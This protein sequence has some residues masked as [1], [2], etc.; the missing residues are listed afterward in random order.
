MAQQ[1]SLD[2]S[3][4]KLSEFKKHIEELSDALTVI[5]VVDGISY[6]VEDV[7]NTSITLEIKAGE[8]L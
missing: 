4:M 8:E 2:K 7:D 6:E 1:T 3:C 5:I